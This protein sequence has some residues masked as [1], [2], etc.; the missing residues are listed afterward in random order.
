MNVNA[1]ATSDS[2]K[3][4]SNGILLNATANVMWNYLVKKAN[5][6][7]KNFA[8]ANLA[9]TAQFIVELMNFSIQTHVN[10]LVF[11][12]A[13]NWVNNLTKETANAR[14]MDAIGGI[15]TTTIRPKQLLL[16]SPLLMKTTPSATVIANAF[17]QFK[18]A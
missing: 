12:P 6:G 16:A 8:N 2:V 3:T 15:T 7:L 10:V 17:A 5:G 11:Q 9:V 1:P 14:K 4:T 13:V 18:I